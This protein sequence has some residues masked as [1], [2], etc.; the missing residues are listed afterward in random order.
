MRYDE[1]SMKWASTI[2]TPSRL[3]DGIEEAADTLEAELDGQAP[4]F[5][6][7]FASAHH[8][9]HFAKLPDCIAARFPGAVLLGCSAGGVIGGGRELEEEA[10]VSLTAAAL[11]GV[12]V[13]PFHLDSD[14]SGWPDALDALGA[15]AAH[16]SALLVLAEPFT[17]DA[18]AMIDWLDA[19]LPAVPKL[20]GVAS[21][22]AQ[23]GE[24]ALFAGDTVHR[25]GAV[26][27]ALAGNIEVDTVVAQGCRPIGA[28]MFVTRAERNVLHE[29]DGVPAMEAL[30]LLHGQLDARD[31]DLFRSSLL[32]GLVMDESRE[33]YRRGD[34][35]IRNLLGVDPNVGAL[36]VGADV[37]DVRVVQFHLRDADTSAEDLD[38]LLSL[39]RPPVDGALVFSCVGRGQQLYGRPN[40]DSDVFARRVGTVPLGG[41]FCGGEIGPVG[42][43][44]FL[45]GY[46]SAFGLFRPRG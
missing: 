12:T 20:G 8:A 19:R 30:E 16:A 17:C 37:S 5:I 18:P 42:G 26:G 46:T 7:A 2:A 43:R 31:R 15:D 32:I 14:S 9:D 25:T 39:S 33:M 36:A 40:H 6:A 35:L 24:S 4:S 28:P 38:A 10:A 23:P 41:F 21:G 22:A 45:H 44:T 27:V 3:E 34:F 1:R 11:P 13:T 29:L